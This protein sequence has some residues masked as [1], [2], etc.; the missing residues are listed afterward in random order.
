[1]QSFAKM[2]LDVLPLGSPLD[3]GMSEKYVEG[4]EGT[5][6][7]EGLVKTFVEM[8][9]N[10]MTVSVADVETLRQAQKEPEKFMDLRVRMGGWSAYFTML[11][12]EQQELHIKKS[13]AGF[14]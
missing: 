13:E 12:K 2:S 1:M 14:M 3:I 6:R 4:E 9:G 11:S 10:L 5:Q 7:L 8:G